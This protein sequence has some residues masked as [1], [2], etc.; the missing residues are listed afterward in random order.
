[1]IKPGTRV[2]MSSELKRALRAS[3]TRYAH[4]DEQNFDLTH[5]QEFGTCIGVV[6]GL[7]DYNNHIDEYDPK[8][9]GPEV[10]VMWMPDGLVYSYRQHMLIVLRDTSPLPFS[11]EV[12]ISIRHDPHLHRALM[13]V[14]AAIR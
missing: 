11:A 1:M 6:L 4:L 3:H 5:T 12:A 9:I 14:I 10:D 7:T 13:L 2:K 8:K